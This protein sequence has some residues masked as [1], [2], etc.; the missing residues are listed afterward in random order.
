[1][2]LN[3]HIMQRRQFLRV[4]GGS[5]IAAATLPLAGCSLSSEMPAA[6]VQAWA[7]PGAEPDVRRWILGWAILAPH[8]HNLQSW[9]VD[10]SKADEITLYCDRTRLLPETDPL[11]RQMMMSQGTFLELLDIAARERGLRAD[12]ELFPD[13]EFGPVVV[14]ARPTA[15]IR[16][17]RD[18]T[19]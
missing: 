7:G 5:S 17:V 8:S 6:A 19:V 14:D 2:S 13:G 9:L 10:L 4:V 3:D 16:L 11:S 12:I 1:M 18:A 15:R